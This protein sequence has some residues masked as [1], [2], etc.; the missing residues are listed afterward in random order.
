MKWNLESFINLFDS[1]EERFDPWLFCN[2]IFKNITNYTTH[3][4]SRYKRYFEKF[5]RLQIFSSN[6]NEY[7][8]H[9][10]FLFLTHIVALSREFFYFWITA[11]SRFFFLFL[12]P[13]FSRVFMT[14]I[15]ALSRE[16]ATFDW[17]C[18][19]DFFFYF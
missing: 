1:W 2:E 13:T 12:T 17:Q 3:C 9:K 19:H 8:F 10:T 4:W 16:F 18:F 14:H 15:V 11:F 5:S 6:Y 7:N